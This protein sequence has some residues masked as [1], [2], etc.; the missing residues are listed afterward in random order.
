MEILGLQ[1]E[2]EHVGEQDIERAGN[3]PPRITAEIGGGFE[4][5]LAAILDSRFFAHGVIS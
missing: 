2:R 5:G 4:R 1:I 3:I